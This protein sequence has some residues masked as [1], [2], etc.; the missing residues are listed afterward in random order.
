[1]TALTDPKPKAAS[2]VKNI[3]FKIFSFIHF[4]G[5]QYK[6]DT[7][8]IV[9]CM[10]SINLEER[11]QPVLMMLNEIWHQ[12]MDRHYQRYEKAEEWLQ[13]GGSL[14]TSFGMEKLKDGLKFAQ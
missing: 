12:E 7:S 4:R 5:H 6:H 3:G 13:R 11:E 10:N 14:L 2:Y 1:M 8:S 9:E